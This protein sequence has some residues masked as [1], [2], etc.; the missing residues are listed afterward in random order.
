MTEMMPIADDAATRLAFG[1]MRSAYLD[2]AR[3]LRSIEDDTARE[4]LQA[5]EHRITYRLGSFEKEAPNGAKRNTALACAAGHVRAV[6]RE[7]REN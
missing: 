4:L 5:V 6:L 2:L 1:I 3:T 7:A